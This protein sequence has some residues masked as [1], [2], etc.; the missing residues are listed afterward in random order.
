MLKQQQREADPTPINTITMVLASCLPLAIACNSHFYETSAGR[1]CLLHFK[2]EETKAY[3][4]HLIFPKIAKGE[5][6]VEP[7]CMWLPNVG[8]PQNF[9]TD[10]MLFALLQWYLFNAFPQ[11]FYRAS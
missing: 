7:N 3:S 8:F 1:R 2:F 5:S 4:V 9:N 10:S 6:G 11:F